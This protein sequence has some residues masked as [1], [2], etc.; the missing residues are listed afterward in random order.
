[1]A[2]GTM[3]SQP[4]LLVSLGPMRDPASKHKVDC[5]WG[6]MLELYTLIYT[7]IRGGGVGNGEGGRGE[8]L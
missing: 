5:T 2:P 4:K 3:L 6:M 1:M 7:G 8:Q